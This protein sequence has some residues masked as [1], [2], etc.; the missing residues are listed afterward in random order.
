MRTRLRLI[1]VAL[2]ALCSAG[3]P[4]CDTT[5]I[6]RGNPDD[7]TS[8]ASEY[9]GSATPLKGTDLESLWEASETVLRM[10]GYIIDTERSSYEKREMLTH[11]DTFLAPVRF[12]GKRHR[13]IVKF[14]EA[15]EGGWIVSCVVQ[16]QRNVDIDNPSNAAQANWEDMAAPE[17]RSRV[18]LYRIESGFRP[19]DGS[20]EKK[21]EKKPD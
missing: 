16:L 9:I 2:V 10:E 4:G 15:P 14:A 19:E 20:D 8:K 11:W 7:A 3:C 6:F 5:R 12:E 17:T 21:D 18:I 1:S 13:A